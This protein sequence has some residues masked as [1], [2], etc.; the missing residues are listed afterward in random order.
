MSFLDTPDIQSRSDSR[1]VESLELDLNRLSPFA[2]ACAVG[3]IEAVKDVC[4]HLYV[5]VEV[6][7]H[8]S[9]QSVEGELLTYEELKHPSTLVFFHLLYSAH[10][11]SVEDLLVLL[12]IL[13]SSSISFNVVHH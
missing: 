5:M 11:V 3:Q 7:I 12:D 13:T 4:R 2:L 9:R 8:Q 10:S 1:H 6:L